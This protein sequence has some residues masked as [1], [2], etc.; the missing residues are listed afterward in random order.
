MSK[1]IR[2]TRSVSVISDVCVL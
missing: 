2:H 1:H